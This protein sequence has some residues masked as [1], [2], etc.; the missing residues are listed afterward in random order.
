MAVTVVVALG[1]SA[2][3]GKATDD[4][5]YDSNTNW[6]RRCGPE[7]PCGG[8]LSC[9]CGMC[10][11]PCG[12]D[13]E[14]ALLAD[15]SCE[16]ARCD[17]APPSGGGMCVARCDADRTCPDGF[18]CTDGSCQP[19]SNEPPTAATDCQAPSID[20]LFDLLQTDVLRLPAAERR[21]ARYLGLA[22]RMGAGACWPELT[23]DASALSKLVNTL[24]QTAL[25]VLPEVVDARRSVYRIDLR[26]YGW[27]RPMGVEGVTH[28]DGWEAVLAA[29]PYAVPYAGPQAD[30]L[31]QATA[32]AVPLLPSN[33]FVHAASRGA[34][35][36]ALAGLPESLTALADEL[37]VA[38]D[39]NRRSG[40]MQRAGTRASVISRE[41]R[42]VERHDTSQ[43][44]G[45]LWLA[46]DR[47]RDNRADSLLIAPLES[48]T[49]GTV[50]IFQQPNGLLAFALFD[51]AGRSVSE[52][53]LLF[54]TLQRDFVVRGAVS[55]LGC[56]AQGLLPVTDQ[57]REFVLGAPDRYDPSV[58]QTVATVY[59][60]A[61]ELDAIIAAESEAYARALSDVNV[62]SDEGDAIST[63]ALGF[64]RDLTPQDVA[65]ELL[66]TQQWLVTVA[67]QLDPRLATGGVS[68]LEFDRLYE[69]SLCVATATAQNRP[70]RC[71]PP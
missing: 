42:L 49:D 62:L 25:R 58:V 56:H 22:N 30:T 11:Q 1:H 68:R 16:P 55:C 39:G 65:G 12:R 60:P 50:A 6:L 34:L 13:D 18:E 27:N 38:L 5:N 54:D 36:Q 23:T 20:E 57:V 59:P 64:E 63:V 67:R 47:G 15:A 10:S 17:G 70:T 24:S 32:T 8:A 33:A 29:T 40:E 19:D 51:A 44:G 4:V 52:S 71:G 21:F 37:G 7:S 28:S 46:L 66:V 69:A 3:G 41:E 45:S 31:R 14:C 43:R 9:V 61:G 53:D 26:D 2:C 35:Y 48:T